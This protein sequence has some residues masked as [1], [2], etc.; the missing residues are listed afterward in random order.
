ME[1]YFY[2]VNSFA[3]AAIMIFISL[4]ILYFGYW[5]GRKKSS[6]F[7]D[8]MKAQITTS[9]TAFLGLFSFLMAFSFGAALH[10]FDNRS[11]A[12]MEEA[13]AIGTTYLR[14]Q[15]LPE[16]VKND[17]LNLLK[18][19]IDIRV[20]TVQIPINN[21][22]ERDP[23]L[24]EASLIRIKLWNLTL[25]ALEK[26]D[27]VATT[28]LYIQALNELMDS[29]DKRDEAINW[30]I[31][32]VVLLSLTFALALWAWSVGYSS[33]I[34]SHMPSRIVIAFMI[35]VV[36]MMSIIIDL[37]RPRR[38]LIQVSQKN[39]MDLKNEIELFQAEH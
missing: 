31:P 1:Q 37:D 36:I 33:A 10:H 22:F 5:L 14:A 15:M 6:V 4:L 38:G 9:Q 29:Y 23:L 12:M 2:N 32:T 11:E 8:P 20:Q 24:K 39:M 18:S 16:S 13:S 25:K 30:N 28:G 27:R 7:T 35:S 26:D 3:I 17:T 21:A 34:G 19:Y